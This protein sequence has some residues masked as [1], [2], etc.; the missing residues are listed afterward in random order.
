MSTQQPPRFLASTP[1]ASPSSPRA[2]R[3]ATIGLWVL[4]G[5][6]AAVFVMAGST[7]LVMPIEAM[8]MPVAL[9][10]W[11]L[12]FIG[13]AEV[14]GAIGLIVPSVTR[15]R[16]SLTPL[17]ACGLVVI[18]IG[19]VSVTLLGGGG[20]QALGPA[21]VGALLATIAVGRT[22][23]APIASRRTASQAAAV[24]VMAADAASVSA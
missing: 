15:I 24:H 13:V 7:K 12:R 20:V 5:L 8:A 11:F 18:M 6:L 16:P 4:Q 2:A 1:N 14:L 3:R 19:A 21:I 22:R 10:E 9:P 23:R 17:A